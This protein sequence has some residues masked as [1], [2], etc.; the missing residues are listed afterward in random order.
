MLER[1]R[2]V[3]LSDDAIAL[4]DR[5]IR[6]VQQSGMGDA[7]EV[8]RY[9]AAHRALLLRARQ[10]G[11][12]LAWDDFLA[13]IPSADKETPPED[14]EA[15]NIMMAVKELLGTDTW[16]ETREVFVRDL[17][18]LLTDAAEHLIESLIQLAVQEGTPEAI[19]GARYLELHLRL[20]REA[21]HAGPRS[22]LAAFRCR[23]AAAGSHPRAAYR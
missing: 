13:A 12:E 16:H 21:R 18:H 5:F 15:E 8:A 20:L 17:R 22:R 10:V 4:L 14:A 6:D 3:L 7:A 9:L 11:V 23:A 19:E 1:E 2:E